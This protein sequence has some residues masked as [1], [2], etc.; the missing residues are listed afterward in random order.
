MGED[1]E[2]GL[3]GYIHDSRGL[4]A[5]CRCKKLVVITEFHIDNSIP[6][7]PESKEYT[8]PGTLRILVGVQKTDTTFFISHSNERIGYY[9]VRYCILR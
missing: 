8:R 1:G 2:G 9:M 5:R 7:D 6:V 4:V 3:P